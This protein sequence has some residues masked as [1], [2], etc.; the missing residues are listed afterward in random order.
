MAVSDQPIIVAYA[1][2]GS[3]VA[4]AVPFYF[5]AFADLVVR[6]KNSS[7]LI[8]TL[9][10]T[11]D[12]TV[13]GTLDPKL[14]T[15][16]A[17]GTV[18][19]NTMLATGTLY[20]RRKTPKAQTAVY[21]PDDPFP[22]GTHEAALDNEILIAQ[23]QAAGG[24]FQPIASSGDATPVD[25]SIANDCFEL[26]TEN[27]T[28]GAPSNPRDGQVLTFLFTNDATPRVV[29]W[30]AIFHFAG[31]AAPVITASKDSVVSFKYNLAKNL[32]YE[33]ARALGQ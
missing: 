8:V 20:I 15:Y 10:L 9:A 25:A 7:G 1:T 19:T 21:A 4:F 3:T 16:S 14:N 30:N 23:E 27:T 28:I 29:S 12:Y 6:Y 26:L 5:R 22:A 31:S 32:W 2:N 18:T 17:G 11:T 33:V 13:A 24:G